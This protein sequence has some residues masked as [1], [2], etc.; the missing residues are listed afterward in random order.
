MS[1]SKDNNPFA[2]E[3]LRMSQTF[4]TELGVEKLLS[5]ISVRKPHKQEF[6][7]VHK[8]EGHRLDTAVLEFKED[9]E[10]YLVDP[11]MQ[12][13]LLQDIFPARLYTCINRQGVLFFWPC[14]LPGFDGRTN[15][16]WESAHKAAEIAMDKWT[17]IVA[18]MHLG[19]YQPYVAEVDLPEPEWP[20][21]TLQE[22]LE[23]AFSNHFIDR[24]DHPVIA[25]LLGKA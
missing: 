9:R 16:W 12:A 1:K 10:V 21:L 17:K 5:H 2:P 23:I 11:Q 19:G 15:A 25:R 20:D 18:D 4:G 7:R 6:L 14:R 22:L 13:A 24:A 3:N 8:S